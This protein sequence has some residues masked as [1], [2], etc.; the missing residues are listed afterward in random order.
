MIISTRMACIRSFFQPQMYVDNTK[1]DR[2]PE[3]LVK[4]LARFEALRGVFHD[5][6]FA[7]DSVKI[8]V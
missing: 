6:G 1:L 7:S 2:N 4:E 5:S 8:N 3:S